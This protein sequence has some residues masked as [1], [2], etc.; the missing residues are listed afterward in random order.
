MA[1]IQAQNRIKNLAKFLAAVLVLVILW[2]FFND[3]TYNLIKKGLVKNA[4]KYIEM[5]AYTKSKPS[6]TDKYFIVQGNDTAK[7]FFKKEINIVSE[8][9]LDSV[10]CSEGETIL[11]Y[12]KPSQKINE[13]VK[14]KGGEELTLNKGTD[15]EFYIAKIKGSTESCNVNP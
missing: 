9:D 6:F 5:Y 3:S 14:G 15:I 11:I 4:D 2:A 13:F 12:E 8:S 7:S 1:S 10:K